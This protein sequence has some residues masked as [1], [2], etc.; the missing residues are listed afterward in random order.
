MQDVAAGAVA[1]AVAVGTRLV[2]DA[3]LVEL[4]EKGM[5]GV[6]GR[7]PGRAADPQQ[8]KLLVGLLRLGQARL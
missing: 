1:V 6:L 3:G 2:A 8:A 5:G 7:T 4:R